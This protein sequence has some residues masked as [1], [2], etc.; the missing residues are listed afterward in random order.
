VKVEKNISQVDSLI[1]ERI[2]QGD[3]SV[4]SFR[5]DD[6]ESPELANILSIFSSNKCRENCIYLLEVLDSL[7]DDY[8]SAK[9]WCLTNSENQTVE[10]SLMKCIRSFRWI[11]STVD[12]DLHYATDLFYDSE[13][14]RSLLGSVAP[15]ALP[16]VCSSYH[17]QPSDRKKVSFYPYQFER[18]L[19]LETSFFWNRYQADH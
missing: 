6:W 1:A 9:A 10:S 8:Y 5:V 11:A 16:Q 13:N 12:D 7:W 15:Y 3:I 14:V 17:Y 2:S 19:T 18:A 4:T